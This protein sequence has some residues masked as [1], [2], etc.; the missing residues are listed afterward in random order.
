[1]DKNLKK[2]VTFQQGLLN[3]TAAYKELVNILEDKT[4]TEPLRRIIADREAQIVKVEKL[5]GEKLTPKD[6]DVKY[7]RRM[8]RFFGT[9]KLFSNLASIM[10]EKGKETRDLADIYPELKII[11]SAEAR[12]QETFKRLSDL[13]KKKKK[14]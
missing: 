13:V 7:V 1:M 6:S 9:Q 3:E 4:Y 2:L 12:Y 11:A 8:N 14:L 5:T 10:K